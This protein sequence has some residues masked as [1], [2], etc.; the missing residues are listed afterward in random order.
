MKKREALLGFVL[1]VIALILAGLVLVTLFVSPQESQTGVFTYTLIGMFPHDE[2]AFTEGLVF[3]D[4]LLYES[5]GLYASSSLRVVDPQTGNVLKSLNL[6]SRYFG[7]GI[8]IMDAK[9]YQLTWKEKEGFVYNQT[10]LNLIQNFVY[11]TQGWGLTNDGANLIMSDGTATLRFLNPQTIQVTREI[12]VHDDTG[13]IVNLNE[14]EYVKNHIYANVWFTSRIA[15]INPQTGFIEAW[16]N[17][18][19][20]QDSRGSMNGIAYDAEGDRFFITGKNWRHVYTIRI[21]ETP[22]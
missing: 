8:T 5:T 17:L 1:V 16:I 18:D 20:L 19:S 3:Q 12:Q 7:E 22:T 21:E 2:N 10:S 6:S 11:S 14:L 13:P 9:I 4:G 15:V